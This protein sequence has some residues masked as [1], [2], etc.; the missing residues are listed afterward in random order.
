MKKGRSTQM[1]AERSDLLNGLG[2]VWKVYEDN[3]HEMLDD[4]R[5][6]KERHGD[7]LV[8]Q[9]YAPNPPLGRWVT[10]QRQAYK[11]MLDGEKIS[12]AIKERICLLNE[13]GFVWVVETSGKWS[14]MFE[15]LKKYKETH[16]NCAVPVKCPSHKHLALWVQKQ[17]RQYREM[18]KGRSTQMTAERSDLLNGL[19]F[20]WKVYEDNWHEM[21]DDLRK[22]K[23]RHG[24]YL[25][26]QKY[27]PNRQLGHWVNNQRQAYKRM[28]KGEKQSSMAKERICVLNEMGFVWNGKA[29]E[30]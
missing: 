2:F 9:K 15:E 25:V 22:Y 29:S 6:Y 7:C 11:H 10:N 12:S 13:I 27:G 28:L 30:K 19:G 26:P 3:W 5:K 17:R 18:K 1:T 20:V 16:G 23:E 4:L 8:P 24:D 21:L 14:D